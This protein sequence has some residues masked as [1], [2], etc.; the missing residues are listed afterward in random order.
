M[1]ALTCAGHTLNLV[2]QNTLKSQQ[3]ISRCVGAAR[4][5]V[6]HFKKSELASTKLK[7]KQRHMGTKE[8]MLLQD[9]CTHWNSTYAM[10]SRLQEQRWPV[11]ATLSDPEVTQRGKHYLDL[12]S[13]QW[14]LI[15]ELNQVLE[16]FHSAT[17][18]MSGEQYVTLSALPH[19]VDKI[20]KSLQSQ[21]LESPPVVSFQTHAK[22]QVTTRWKD[23]GEFKP[24]SPNIT[25]LAASLDPRFRKLKFL[26]A[27]QAFGVKNALQTMALAVKQQ[28]GPTGCGNEASS[29]A[30]GAPSTA[31]KDKMT[32]SF[33][34]SDS[35]SSDEEQ[36][37]EQLSNE[38]IQNEVLAYF[39]EQS[40][41]KKDGPL[42]W[43]KAN[44]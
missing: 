23:L 44:E 6:E 9:V 29:T 16:P 14:S 2:V 27:D 38:A 25:L 7:V 13:D 40:L 20:K 4:T 22:E 3:A 18:F 43:W 42:I 1:G 12:K 28:L 26:P 24:E 37:E 31:H 35:T 21:N 5:L 30:E 33:L 36:D 32:T 8:N 39:G 41:P 19:V 11:T 17:V 10:L 15:E 34:D